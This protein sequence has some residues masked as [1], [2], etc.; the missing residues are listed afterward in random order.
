MDA[1]ERKTDFIVDKLFQCKWNKD[2]IKKELLTHCCD[3][4]ELRREVKMEKY[5]SSKQIT[6]V[7]RKFEFVR[8]ETEQLEVIHSYK[9][10]VEGPTSRENSTDTETRTQKSERVNIMNVLWWIC[11]RKGY[12]SRIC[13][14][15]KKKM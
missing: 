9:D 7:I 3:D 13:P 15:R 10:A 12:M 8:E 4:G 2:V 11:N 5:E 14:Q 6:D 1:Y